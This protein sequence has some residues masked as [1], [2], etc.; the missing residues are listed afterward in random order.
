MSSPQKKILVTGATG[1]Q[2]GCTIEAL[3]ASSSPFHILALTRDLNSAKA[4]E[5]ASKPNITVV[6]GDFGS[7]GPIF[8]EYKP[9]YGVFG[10]TIPRGRVDEEGQAKPLIDAALEHG[11]EHFVFTSVD[12]GGE[13]SDSTAT[14]I[15]HFRS[16]HNIE[17]YLKAQ[18]AA[19]E[20]NMHYTI[21]RPVAFMDNMAPNFFGKTFATMWGQIGTKPLQLISS[22]DIGVFA[23]NAFNNPAAYK[24]RA[25]ALAGDELTLEQGKKVFKDTL[26]YDMP[27][28]YGFVGSGLKYMMGELGNMF[29]W[30][31]TNGYGADIQA[32]R[33]EEPKLQDFGTWLKESSGFKKQ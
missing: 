2:G 32:L 13:K 14:D 4:K 10:V 26:G 6:K 28:T 7:V 19:R 16:K 3:Q 21:L 24:N 33:K 22:H 30:F 5:L 25:V 8:E 31:K 9:I 12:R 18:I 27:E 11:V 23:A 17:Q 20:S 29:N 1:K 15:P